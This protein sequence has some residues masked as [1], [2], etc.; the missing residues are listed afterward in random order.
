MTGNTETGSAMETSTSGSSDV[1]SGAA[2]VASASV[3]DRKEF[4]R[5]LSGD[6]LG[7]LPYLFD[8][9]ALD[10][11]LAPKVDWRTWVILGGCGAGKT[12]A[13]AGWVR[14]MVEGT[15]PRDGGVAKRVGLIGETTAWATV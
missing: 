10:H 11:Q 13:G 2:L 6:H 15:R 1:T 8:F 4:L 7:A 14:S 5:S 12:R 9:W 3:A